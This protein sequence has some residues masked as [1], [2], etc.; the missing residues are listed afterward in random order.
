M[1]KIQEMRSKILELNRYRRAY[2]NRNQ[3]LVSNAE[4]DAMF[5]ELEKMER[6][7]GIVYADSPTQHVG[8][9]PEG[10]LEKIRHPVPLLSLDKTKEIQ[11]LKKFAKK[12]MVLLMLKLDGLTIK[13]TYEKGRLLE[14]ATRGDGETGENVLRNVP[15]IKGI[16]VTI[17][18][19]KR[20]VLSGEAF[21]R[22]DDFKRLQE[23]LRDE[24][25]EAP[26][27]GRNLA[28]G[29][30]QSSNP[31]HCQGRCVRFMPFN[32][33]EGLEEIREEGRGK[34]LSVL[35][36]M[37]FSVCPYIYLEPERSNEETEL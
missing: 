11:E 33:L 7:T 36:H 9:Y 34:C 37:G 17:P 5:E 13:L 12:N 10:K 29:S 32:V 14:A 2:Y 3:S 21:I 18:Y 1:D 22:Q 15:F 30:V 6:E 19:Q 23:V 20:L 31:K 8:Y 24:N 25:G 28:S 26:K 27:N 16:P 4:Y 35:E